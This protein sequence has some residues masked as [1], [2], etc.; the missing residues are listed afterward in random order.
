MTWNFFLAEFQKKYVGSVYLEERRREF[1][2]LQQRKLSVVEY[3]REF[4]RLSRYGRE[5]VPNKAKRC[6][7]FKEG[8]KDNIKLM[9]T[10]LGITDFAKLV[11]TVLK[12]EKV[13]INEQSRRDR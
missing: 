7:R 8:L 1:I 13:R 12:V 4:I 11:E 9:V 2:S 5:I 3:E 10:A 6:R